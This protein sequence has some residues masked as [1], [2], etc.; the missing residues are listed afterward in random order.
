MGNISEDKKRELLNGLSKG[1][2]REN[3]KRDDFVKDLDRLL[4]KYNI[5]SKQY[6]SVR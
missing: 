1:L 5:D 3:T 2:S 6:G 4:T